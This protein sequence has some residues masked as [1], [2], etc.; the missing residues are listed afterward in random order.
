MRMRSDWILQW[1]VPHLKEKRGRADEREIVLFRTKQYQHVLQIFQCSNVR[2]PI[3]WL[4]VWSKNRNIFSFR[5]KYSERLEME[6]M[7]MSNHCFNGRIGNEFYK[8]FDF[9]LCYVSQIGKWSTVHRRWR[10]RNRKKRKTIHMDF[11]LFIGFS[12]GPSILVRLIII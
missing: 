10:A 7:E 5:R 9:H 6:H 1:F 2:K 8:L 12:L 11:H 4:W 3:D